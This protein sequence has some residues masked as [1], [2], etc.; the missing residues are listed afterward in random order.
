MA[1]KRPAPASSSP[2]DPV[3]A[4][5]KAVI[6]GMVVAGPHIRAACVRH[7]GDLEHGS[8]RGLHWDRK[9]VRRVVRFFDEGLCL[10]GG[11]FEGQPFVLHPSQAFIVGSLFGWQRPDGT[12]RFRRAYIEQGKGSGKSPLAAGVGMYCLLADGEPRA[13]VYAAA[14]MKS[15]AMVLFRDAVAMWQ[16]S[17]E[18]RDRLTPS[19]GN[20]IWNLTDLQTGSF[21]RPIS[22]EEDH[23]GPRP[24]CALCDEI[25]EHRNGHMI[26][27]L[28][29]GF[30]FRRQPLLIMITNAGTDRNSVCWEEHTHAVKVASGEVEDDET[31]S[32]VCSLDDT[33]DPLEDPSCWAKAN[34]LLNVTI[35]EEYLAGVVRQAKQLP[36]KLNNILRLHFCRWTD[37]EQAWMS[38]E[39]LEQVLADFD[40]LQHSGEDIFLGLDLSATQDLTALAH[41]VQTGVDAE[42]RPTFDAWIE[43]WTPEATVRERALRDKAPYERWIEQ[44]DLQATPGKVIGF[45]YVAARLAEV[46]SLYSV[47]QLAYDS[48]GFHKHFEPALDALGLTLPIVE[49]P[50]GGKRKAAQSGLWMPGSKLTLETLILERRIQ[51]RRNPVL[52]SAM[53]AAATENDPFGNFWFSKRRALSRIDA[54]IALGMAVGAATAVEPTLE[55]RY[56]LFVL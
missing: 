13:E 15:Q 6:A 32:F 18:L 4:W 26:E 43:A 53:M 46:A 5:A 56:Q 22:S 24:S 31:F 48:Y 28:E 37:A 36:G 14:S 33:D 25:H 44:G 7:L 11:Q 10:A 3:T 2:D 17:G 54:L 20:P 41:V 35:T 38:R 40:P 9:A 27:M 55:P 42:K 8:S 49:H 23:S 21:F 16:Q 34:P 1:R 50:Q 45:D 51:I 12:R 39:T 47:R 19:G 52:V 29:R 30:K